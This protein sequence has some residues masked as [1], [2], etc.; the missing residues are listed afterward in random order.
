VVFREL[1]GFFKEIGIGFSRIVL[2]LFKNRFK[3]FCSGRFG[4]SVGQFD[5]STGFG[6]F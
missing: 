3:A 2:Q 4:F 6:F 1:D 5:L